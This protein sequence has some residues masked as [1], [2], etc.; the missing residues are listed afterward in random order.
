MTPSPSPLRAQDIGRRV[1]DIESASLARAQARIGEAFDEAVELLLQCTGRVVVS[2]VGKSGLIARK[3][4]ATMNST[5]TPAIFLHPADAVHGDLGMVR[6]EDAVLLLSKSGN[7]EEIKLLLPILTR[8]GL[9]V[10]A[11]VGKVD[12]AIGHHADIVLD[13]SVE[14]E[15]C[16]HDLAPTAST[17][18]ALALGDA[19]AIALLEKRGFTPEDFALYHP[20]GSLGKRLLLSIDEIMVAGERMPSVHRAV[21]LRDAI[22]EMTSKR[23]GATCVTDDNGKLC[24]MITDGDLRRMLERDTDMTNLLAFDVMSPNPKTL[25]PH[26]LASM[27]LEVME[28]FKIT[29]LI[30]VNA[31]R[32]PVGIVHMHDLVQLGLR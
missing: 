18:V 12:S 3:I 11:L 19:L 15:A 29:Q 28:Q 8:I 20:G 23:L 7:T 31:E 30:V 27:A 14:E 17:T 21:S 32:E 25:Y 10:I 6:R 9:P 26:A 16:P 24:G 2:G 22:L 4:V 1:L 5:G 13:A